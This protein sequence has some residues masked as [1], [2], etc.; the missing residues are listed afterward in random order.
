MTQ[1]DPLRDLLVDAGAVDRQQIADVLRGRI[2]IDS[3]SGRL[4]LLPGFGRLE[5]RRKILTVLL[6]RKAAVLLE[7]SDAEG[8]TNKQV[9]EMTG[10]ATGTAA[11]GLKSLRELRL[12]GQDSAKAYLVPNAHLSDVIQFITGEDEP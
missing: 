12:V 7:A 2:A 11:P 10:L 5:A 1:E 3:E 6:A 9:A 4:L 8:L